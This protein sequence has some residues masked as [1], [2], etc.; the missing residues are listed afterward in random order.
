MPGIVL[1]NYKGGVGKTTLTREL[2]GSMARKQQ[3]SLCIDMDPQ[4]NLSRRLGFRPDPAG[5][6][7]PTLAGALK[8]NRTGG[9]AD[10]LLPCGWDDP[11][12]QH[13]DLL[14]A[15]FDLEN[16]ISEAGVVGAVLRLR[17][18][19]TGLGGHHWRLYDCPPSLGHLTQMSLVA[20]G[21]EEQCGVVLVTEPE[22]D[23][24]EGCIKAA[25]FVAGYAPVLG[26]PH[27]QVVGIVV[28]R[29]RNTELHQSNIAELVDRFGDLVWEPYMPLWNVLADAHNSAVPLHTM[30][31]SK[32]TDLSA[33]IDVLADRLIKVMA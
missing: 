11:L 28:N 7:V 13:I 18:I 8:D 21:G 29:N 16:R 5:P 30:P 10:V 1:M 22:Y 31:G 6:V 12:A 3:R 19:M 2:A 26:V 32:A 24:L 4:A 9:A 25:E 17:N 27:L 33:R 20:G 23:S 14:P 15:S